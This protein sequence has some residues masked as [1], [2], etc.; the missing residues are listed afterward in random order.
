MS[1]ISAVTYPGRNRRVA[2]MRAER[3]RDQLE[4]LKEIV[5][6][7]CSEGDEDPQLEIIGLKLDAV[8]DELDCHADR[9]EDRD[10]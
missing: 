1:L 9:L 8:A 5:S 10:V 2:K 4:R 7:L 3:V 6:A